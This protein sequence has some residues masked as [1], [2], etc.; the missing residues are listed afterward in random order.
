[1]LQT[2]KKFKE[3]KEDKREGSPSK[4]RCNIYMK[5]E[6]LGLNLYALLF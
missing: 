5:Y 2:Q 6:L 1:M 4:G 3:K